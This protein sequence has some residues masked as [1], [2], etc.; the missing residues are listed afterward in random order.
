MGKYDKDR[1][2]KE[3]A[4]RYCLAQGMSPCLEVIVASAA[5][6]SDAPEVLTDLDVVGLEY[7][8]DGDLRRI[9]F[10]CKTTNK[11]SAINRAFWGAGILAYSG[12]DTA[13]IIL[14]NRAVYNH[15][16]SALT[17]GVDLHD[18]NS[19]EEIGNAVDVAFNQDSFYQSS[20]DR[21]NDVYD[22]YAR[23]PWAEQLYL[24]GRNAAPLTQQPWRV[25]RR[26]VAELRSAKGQFDP[27]KPA[28][29][30]VYFDLMAAV[31]ILWSTMGRDIRRFYDSKMSKPEFEK[32]LRYYIWGGKESYQV[33]QELRQKTDPSGVSQDFPSWQ[34]LVSFAGLVVAGPQN[35]FGCVNICREMSIRLLSGKLA[36][37][38]KRLTGLF[39]ENK[40]ATQ[41]ILGVSDYLIDACNLPKDLG[42]AVNDQFQGL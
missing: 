42:K 8:S 34:R 33:R 18:E 21:W 38:E 9:L 15:R 2:Q 25:F 23:N 32:A 22:A 7:V 3:M 24:I 27:A 26:L 36:E 13:F 1:H 17:L 19:F 39:R 12:C 11:M 37:P 28:H 41:F 16:L 20:I 5:D 29:I 6:L 30:A 31:F 10:D 4:I 14:K 35:L 40:R